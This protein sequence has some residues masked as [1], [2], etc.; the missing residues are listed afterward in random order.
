MNKILIIEELKTIL[1]SVFMKDLLVM[2]YHHQLV[3]HQS[4]YLIDGT[5]Q[6]NISAVKMIA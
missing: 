5:A 4:T 6:Q 3:S 2:E 1:K